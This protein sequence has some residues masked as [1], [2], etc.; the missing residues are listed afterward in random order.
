MAMADDADWFEALTGF[1]E[2]SY[3]ET[4]AKLS[5]HDQRLSSLVNG[6]TYGVGALEVVSLADLRARAPFAHDGATRIR[7]RIVR[8]N[9][10][11]LHQDR[12]N[13][14]ALFQVA[15]QFNLLEMVSPEVSPSDGV[16]RYA[17]D[18]TQGPA[19]AIAAGAATIY[20]NYFA[21][22]PDNQIDTLS[23]I[24]AALS[25]ALDMPL[26]SL[27]TM[28]N[29]Y[30]MPSLSGLERIAAYLESAD[31]QERDA[32]RAKLKI[33]LHIDVEVTEAP[34]NIRPTISQAFCS[35]MPVS[36]TYIDEDVWAPFAALTLEA[37]YEATLRAA[38]WNAERGASNVVFLTQLGGGAFGNRPIWILDAMRRAL[39]LARGADLD[40]RL[41]SFGT[42]WHR[43]REL[44]EDEPTSP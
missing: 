10:R 31:E 43:V 26:K 18:R 1:A 37:A 34:G 29:G 23:D 30:A 19:C 28:R 27:W 6:K 36:Y 9:V 8:G 40:V 15:S 11:E 7:T 5:V 22:R 44:F 4:R 25:E 33:G 38:V 12:S 14:G 16:T 17:Y 3:D 21:Q 42:P 13:A 35:A 39:H 41:V 24:G 32:L 20:R 2:T